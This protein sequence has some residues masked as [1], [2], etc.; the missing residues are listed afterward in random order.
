[1]ESSAYNNNIVLPIFK[2]NRT[3]FQIPINFEETNDKRHTIKELNK[4]QTLIRE[5][6]VNILELNKLRTQS[7]KYETQMKLS[8]S[9]HKL[10]LVRLYSFIHVY[11]N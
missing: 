1:M 9:D 6:A 7:D 5:L 11:A 8:K 4:K 2:E 10:K 3:K